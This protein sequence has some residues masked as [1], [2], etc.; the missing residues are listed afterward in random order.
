MSYGSFF[1]SPFISV[2]IISYLPLFPFLMFPFSEFL[3]MNIYT[4]AI[5]KIFL[6]HFIWSFIPYRVE[7][8]TSIEITF[9]IG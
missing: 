5:T 4:T 3:L 7:E 8:Y 6:T 9:M 1:F 2:T